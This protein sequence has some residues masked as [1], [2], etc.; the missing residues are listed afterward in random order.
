VANR[1]VRHAHSAH[2]RP[3]VSRRP[4]RFAFIGVLV[5]IAV[6]SLWTPLLQPSIASRWFSWPNVLLLSP[7]PI[8]TALIAYWEWRSL[9]N[10]SE[11]APFVGAILLFV[12]SYLGIPISMWPMIVPYKRTLWE[13]AS[14]EATQAFLAV[15]TLFLLSVILMY[16]GWSYWC[17]GAR[18]GRI[19]GIIET[20]RA[21]VEGWAG[22]YSIRV[23]DQWRICFSWREGGPADVEIVCRNR[24]LPT[25]RIGFRIDTRRNPAGGI[26]ATARPEPDGARPRPADTAPPDQRNC[27]WQAGGHGRTQTCVGPG[28]SALPQ[29]SSSACKA[30]TTSWSAAGSSALTSN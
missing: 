2:H 29:A 11:A 28:I 30:I 14:S 9:N 12:M 15:G 18:S 23:N 8:A 1:E 5:A 24:R 16:T 6:V 21:G 25:T 19:S 13:A 27:A 22:Q 20:T 7:V 3:I 10:R 17:S 26:S 4:G